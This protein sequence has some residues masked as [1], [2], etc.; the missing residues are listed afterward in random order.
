MAR[1]VKIRLV[2]SQFVPY[3][4]LAPRGNFA[5]RAPVSLAKR[6]RSVEQIR[7]ARMVVVRS[8]VQQRLPVLMGNSV[9]KVDAVDAKQTGSV[10]KTKY[11]SKLPVSQGAVTIKSA[12]RARYANRLNV[13]LDAE[14]TRV[15]RVSRSVNKTDAQPK[16]VTKLDHALVGCDASKDAAKHAPKTKSVRERSAWKE[17]VEKGVE[18]TN[19][20]RMKSAIQP[21][22]AVS[23]VCKQVTVRAEKFV[24]IA[25]ATYASPIL[26]VVRQ[27]YVK[28]ANAS[29]G[30]AALQPIAKQRRVVTK[31]SVDRVSKI[32]IVEQ[33]RS[34]KP[35]SVGQ[36][37]ERILT[38]LPNK[39]ATHKNLFVQGALKAAIALVGKY[40]SGE[41]VGLVRMTSHVEQVNFV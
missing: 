5:R 21:T 12:G 4:S 19:T 22:I 2:L 28:K 7:S 1:S 37:V 39:S 15:V 41:H 24:E 30:I 36:D 14:M 9:T 33:E 11:A 34:V 13:V 16:P 8:L 26:N 29:K 3:K 18:Q 25:G 38:V 35:R 20:A 32:V 17:H 27:S 6:T 23:H 40:V 10:A 31:T